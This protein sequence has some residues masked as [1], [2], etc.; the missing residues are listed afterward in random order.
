MAANVHE[1]RE[2]RAQLGER[3]RRQPRRLRALGELVDGALEAPNAA[4]E[5]ANCHAV[6]TA[7]TATSATCRHV[8]TGPTV[9]VST[10][11]PSAPT[12]VSN[13]AGERAAERRQPQHRV[14]RREV[15]V[16]PRAV[17]AD[18]LLERRLHRRDATRRNRRTR[19][20]DCGS[21]AC[22]PATRSSRAAARSAPGKFSLTFAFDHAITAPAR[23]AAAARSIVTGA[24]I[25]RDCTTYSVAVARQRP[26]DVLRPAELAL[27]RQAGIAQRRHD[28]RVELERFARRVRQRRRRRSTAPSRDR[29]RR[30]PDRSRR[31]RARRRAR[32]ELDEHRTVGRRREQHARGESRRPAAERPRPSRA[33]AA[34]ARF[35]R[36]A[37]APT[38]TTTSTSS[39]ARS[40][41]AS[42]S[43][44][45]DRVELPGERFAGA[46]F[47]DRRAAHDDRLR[48]RAAAAQRRTL[49]A[50]R[51]PE[52]PHCSPAIESLPTFASAP[53]HRSTSSSAQSSRF[54]SAMPF[55]ARCCS[56]A[57]ARIT[58]PLGTGIPARTIRPSAY[59]FPPTRSRLARLA[60]RAAEL[61]RCA[62]RARRRRLDRRHAGRAFTPSRYSRTLNA[63]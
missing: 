52:S 25:G 36:T 9:F 18:D 45:E 33:P 63:R 42:L 8:P 12:N 39:T 55:C 29:S 51:Y 34:V 47:A 5:P 31:S 38:R 54:V 24:V 20:R 61:V 23:A 22:I 41:A 28:R 4:I 27:E 7:M 1:P 11:S 2:R 26:L 3:H 43:H 10:P 56:S 17:H 58:K 62:S 35:D 44:V 14:D 30:A 59:A 13:D 49:R 40:S 60:E 15:V 50:T 48:A 32:R 37:R 21:S 53:R 57:S 6:F 46:I 16:H 19:R